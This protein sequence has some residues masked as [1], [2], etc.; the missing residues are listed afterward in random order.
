MGIVPKDKGKRINWY[1]VRLNQWAADP[2]GIGATPEQIAELAGLVEEAR[3]ARVA[4]RAAQQAARSATHRLHQAMDRLSRH[5]S[6]VVQRI[7]VKGIH[8]EGAYV[9]AMVPPPRKKRRLAKPGRPYGF[10]FE[11]DQVGWLT[12]CWKCDNPANAA[13]PV[14]QVWRQ[15]GGSGAFEH[16]GTVGKKKFT[17]QTLPAGGA[18]CVTYRVRAIR[19]GKAG[20]AADF[21]VRFGSLTPSAGAGAA[22][23]A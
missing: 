5:G 20:D 14:Y 17:D 3:L 6:R 22:V 13:G 7:R 18:A 12:L 21:Q 16:L 8:D 23:A 4:Q 10:R 19:S 2:Q 11:L 1:K 9:R 15:I